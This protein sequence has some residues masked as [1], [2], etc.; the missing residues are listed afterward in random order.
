[1]HLITVLGFL[2]HREFSILGNV[3]LCRKYIV[4]SLCFGEYAEPLKIIPLALFF[5]FQWEIRQFQIKLVTQIKLVICIQQ[6]EISLC[7]SQK[8]TDLYVIL[9]YPHWKLKYAKGGTT[10]SKAHL[11]LPH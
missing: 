1:M 10:I 6:V 7:C 11:F 9:V 3:F 2:H 5:F 4:S 8:L